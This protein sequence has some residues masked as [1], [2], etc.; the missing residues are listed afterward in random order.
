MFRRNRLQV[1]T[2]HTIAADT[3]I[4]CRAV[5]YTPGAYYLLTV[6]ETIVVGNSELT[7]QVYRDGSSAVYIAEWTSDSGDL[8]WATYKAAHGVTQTE[9]Y[10]YMTGLFDDTEGRIYVIEAEDGTPLRDWISV[11]LWDPSTEFLDVEGWDDRLIA[12]K[13][14]GQDLYILCMPEPSSLVGGAA[15]T[16]GA[17][18]YQLSTHAG[19][20]P[21]ANA[22]GVKIAV[23]P[24][25]TE[26]NT[27]AIV[28]DRV[29]ENSVLYITSGVSPIK[30]H[31]TL[32]T[33]N[34]ID[35]G[36]T[37][38]KDVRWRDSNTVIIV[39]EDTVLQYKIDDTLWETA[40]LS[41]EAEE[42]WICT[43]GMIM[44]KGANGQTSMYDLNDSQFVGYDAAH[45][46][47]VVS[48]SVLKVGTSV[49]IYNDMILKDWKAWASPRGLQLISGIPA[50]PSFANDITAFVA[51]SAD[52]AEAALS[53][54]LAESMTL[55]E[56][57]LDNLRRLR[58][59]DARIK[60]ITERTGVSSEPDVYIT[61][62][63]L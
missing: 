19:A 22:T 63:R 6:K 35:L 50:S 2:T 14:V 36:T 55:S 38:V 21:V 48:K 62:W 29:G 56:S 4:P 18:T 16:P 5:A 3:S 33:G 34:A 7:Y 59:T 41:P 20:I 9:S 17:G 1:V 57:M 31:T 51:Q 58:A 23:L 44:L 15:Y 52:D 61:D 11:F 43:D 26:E 53:A 60:M 12:V 40:A 27:I 45:D 47:D 24:S 8:P 42:A 32:T 39:C 54:I 10:I 37:N 46:A 49:T 30:T 28:V 13:A 25:N